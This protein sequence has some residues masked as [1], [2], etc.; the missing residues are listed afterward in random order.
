MGAYFENK[1]AI[2][3]GK[4]IVFH[5]PHL[6][7]SCIVRYQVGLVSVLL[8]KYCVKYVRLLTMLSP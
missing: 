7:G 4:E 1:L 6:D 2:I 8:V 5:V 3:L